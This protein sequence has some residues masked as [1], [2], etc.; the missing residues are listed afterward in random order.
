[1]PVEDLRTKLATKVCKGIVASEIEGGFVVIRCQ[2]VGS[3]SSGDNAGQ[4]NTAAKLDSAPAP[5]MLSFSDVS[6]ESHG[7][8]PEIRPVGEPLILSE[9]FLVYEGVGR[10]RMRHMVSTVPNF[11]EGFSQLGEAVKVRAEALPEGLHL[12]AK[13]FT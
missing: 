3:P 10:R 5:E 13:G 6:R 11:D 9:L 2:D 8:R 12:S 4:T 1:M 7:A